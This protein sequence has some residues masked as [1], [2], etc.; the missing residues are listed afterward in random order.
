MLDALR[1]E[2]ADFRRHYPHALKIVRHGDVRPGGSECP[3]PDLGRAVTTGALDPRS[4]QEDDM[5]LNPE[6]KTWIE[7]R[8]L[9]HREHTLANLRQ[10]VGV[11]L[12]LLLDDEAKVSAAVAKGTATLRTEL[13]AD[14][15]GA[16]VT[17]EQ[18]ERALRRALAQLGAAD[19]G[20]K[21]DVGATP[22]F[23]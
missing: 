10:T 11:K 22:A 12:N 18:L 8:L 4:T 19:G 23:A 20:V 14:A 15:A 3:G 16:P 6:D 2:I 13:G 9:A 5:P 17:D 1:E 21:S 7:A